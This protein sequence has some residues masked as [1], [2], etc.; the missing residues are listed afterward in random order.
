[1]EIHYYHC[2]NYSLS[3]PVAHKLNHPL[4]DDLRFGGNGTMELS[5][6]NEGNFKSEIVTNE[7][8]SM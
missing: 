7:L 5:D 1:M 4:F 2:L 8:F 3:L 6:L